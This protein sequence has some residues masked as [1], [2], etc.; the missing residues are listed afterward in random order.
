[1]QAVAKVIPDTE[2]INELNEKWETFTTPNDIPG[3]QQRLESSLKERIKCLIA[4]TSENKP[5]KKDKKVQV[6]LLGDETK[7]GE[8]IVCTAGHEF[9]YMHKSTCT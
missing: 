8:S 6:K 7:I 1:M 3:V 5:F 4:S 9:K 2:K